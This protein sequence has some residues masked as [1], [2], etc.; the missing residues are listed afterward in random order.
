LSLDLTP[1]SS[2]VS[3]TVFVRSVGFSIVGIQYSVVSIQWKFKNSNYTRER[4][5]ERFFLIQN[6][7]PK[8]SD[9][10]YR[11]LLRTSNLVLRNRTPP[12]RPCACPEQAERVEGPPLPLRHNLRIL[13]KN[14]EPKRHW[15][16]YHQKVPKRP[17]SETSASCQ[18]GSS[19]IFFS[20]RESVSK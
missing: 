20:S 4:A 16:F 12:L 17:Y 5:R 13:Q 11:I 9:R 15:V 6:P 19:F 2:S 10:I 14:P 3:S 7:R 1:S 8:L 18:S